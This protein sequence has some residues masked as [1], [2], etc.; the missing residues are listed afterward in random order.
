MHSG[1][2]S[3]FGSGFD[4]KKLKDNGQK[5]QKI[6]NEMKTFAVTMLLLTLKKERFCIKSGTGSVINSY[7]TVPQHCQ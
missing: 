3:G 1:S 2:G 4:I 7:R 5:S 6:E